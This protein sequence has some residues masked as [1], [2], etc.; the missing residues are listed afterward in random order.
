MATY[1]LLHNN[2]FVVFVISLL[3]LT[4]TNFHNIS[5]SFML[6]KYLWGSLTL[7]CISVLTLD[8]IRNCGCLS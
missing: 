2:Y 1:G 7:S 3:S 6:S 8:I 5:N 4:L